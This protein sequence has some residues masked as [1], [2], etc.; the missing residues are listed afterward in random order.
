MRALL[1]VPC[2]FVVLNCAAV[3]G[4]YHFLRGSRDIWIHYTPATLR[5]R[6][7]PR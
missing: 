6:L 7:C 3:F 5:T 1:S 4:L 2:T